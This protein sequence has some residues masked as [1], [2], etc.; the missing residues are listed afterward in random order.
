MNKTLGQKIREW[1]MKKG[2]TQTELAEGLVTPSMISQIESDKAN[3]SFKLLEGISR[4]LDVP[5]D[6]FLMDMQSQLEEDTRHKL[7]KSLMES[8]EYDKA[9]LVLEGLVSSDNTMDVEAIKMELAEAYTEAEKYDKAI[10]I[11][12]G[13]LDEIVLDRDRSKAVALNR[14]LGWAKQQ[15]HDYVLARHYQNQALK[16]LAKAPQ[17]SAEEQGVLFLN[18]AYTLTN[19]GVVSE[20]LGFYKKAITA[21]QG[22]SNLL[23]VGMAYMG[24]ANTHGRLGDYQQASE[25]TRTAIT[26]FRSV[27]NK[28]HEIRAKINYG[29][30]QY[31]LEKYDEAITQFEECADEFKALNDTEMVANVYGELGIV[32]FRMKNYKEAEKWCFRALELLPAKH[33]ERAFVYKTLGLMYQELQNYERSLEYM[34]SSVEMFENFGLLGEASKCYAD[35]VNIYQARGELDKAS[36]YMQK[37]SSSIEEGLRARGLYL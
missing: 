27:N 36:E 26:M 6:E 10:K 3:P 2:I 25:M 28:M 17:V 4:K 11:L 24:L 29:I 16:E 13:M 1:R 9:I 18:Y 22:T 30:F 31:E 23:L 35:I 12:E 19:L 14:K 37:A 34:V 5:I 8:K 33:R 21:L 32:Y 20:A 7:A 15:Q